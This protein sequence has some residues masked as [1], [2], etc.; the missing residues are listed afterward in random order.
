MKIEHNAEWFAN[1]Y[2]RIAAEL[3][4]AVSQDV[5]PVHLALRAERSAVRASR[6]V[7]ECVNCGVLSDPGLRN[8]I[9]LWL[10]G[11]IE[12]HGT[13]GKPI[14][15][16]RKGPDGKLLIELQIPES[17]VQ[18]KFDA[19]KVTD[20]EALRVWPFILQYLFATDR[21]AFKSNAGTFDWT[22]YK[23]D[24]EGRP[25]GRDG[26]R[27]R[28]VPVTSNGTK[29][30]DSP[31]RYELNGE[32]VPTTAD[33]DESDWLAHVRNQVGDW[34]DTCR[35]LGRRTGATAV[36]TTE[37]VDSGWILAKGYVASSGQLSKLCKR[38]PNI[39]QSATDSDKMRL[40]KPRIRFVY[41]GR[42]V[43]ELTEGA[44]GD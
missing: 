33:Y 28:L 14:G 1:E 20:A 36:D 17:A 16:M 13:P 44:S 12:A 29:G 31:K 5:K 42:R 18:T 3:E 41:D 38:Y 32:P 9:A 26:K 37:W 6:L 21:L 15:T 19:V 10:P 43:Y 27:L 11:R 25:V 30:D 8:T 40:G 7:M 39:R 2:V 23:T 35:S 22:H 34:A 4:T 24:S